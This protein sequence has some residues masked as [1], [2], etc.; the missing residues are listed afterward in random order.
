MISSLTGTL[1]KVGEHSIEL[2]TGPIGFSVLVPSIDIEPLRGK[3]GR[4]LSLFTIF[5]L[6]GDASRGNLEPRVIGFVREEDRA[7]FELFTTVKGI[8]P[9][10]ALKALTEPVGTIA[11]WIEGRDARSLTKLS[12]IGKRTAELVVAELSG[13]CDKFAIGTASPS[14]TIQPRSRRP[15]EEEDAISA[16]VALGE[17]PQDAS[18]LLD[19]VRSASPDLKKTNDLVREMLRLRGGR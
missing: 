17:R 4:E 18:V 1:S 5:Y 19:R 3:I 12:G 11:A 10:T 13:K 9:K 7:F 6:E 15:G 16:L 8:G 2:R 14:M